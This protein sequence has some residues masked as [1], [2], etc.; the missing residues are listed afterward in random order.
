MEQSTNGHRR[1]QPT[2]EDVA[3]QAGVS[4][5]LVSLV[6]RDQPNVS[7]ARRRR[8]L[9]AAEDLGY[10]PNGMA[11]SLARQRTQTVGAIIDDLGNPFFAEVVGGVEDVAAEL[12]YRVLLAAGNRSPARE[13]SAIEALLEYRVDGLILGA[14][15]LPAREIVRVAT[16]TPV[17]ML[18][19]PVRGLDA[20]VTD[21]QAGVDQVLEH[22]TALGHRRIVHITGGRAPGASGRAAAFR[23]GMQARGLEPEVIPGDFVEAAGVSAARML[24]DRSDPLP[25]AIFS[26]ND[27]QAAGVLGVFA[28]AGIDIPGEVSL[29]GY[30]NTSIAGIAHV[31]L[32]TIDQPRTEIGREAFSLILS[33]IGGRT[34]PV[35]RILT[36]ELVVRAT[37]G[38]PRS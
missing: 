16:Q 10:R 37:T 14:P 32:T 26:A 19:Q 23:R 2:M 5:A 34:E 3:A 21:N 24:L 13:R 20:V 1:R 9:A 18:G 4:R 11:R 30:D 12:G 29:V 33:R 31:S 25:T 38:P 36:P 27:L 15:R 6:F 7:E 17:V 22:L 35:I 28:H 8:V